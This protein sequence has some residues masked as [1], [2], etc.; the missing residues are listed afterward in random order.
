MKTTAIKILIFLSFFSFLFS[1]SSDDEAK[2]FPFEQPSV[3]DA[4]D[5]NVYTAI[6]KSYNDDYVVVTQK[7][8]GTFISCI[9]CSF[10]EQLAEDNPGFEPEMAATLVE[11]NQN[12]LYLDESFAISS[13][14]VVLVSEAQLN[15][16]FNSDSSKDWKQFRNIFQNVFGYKQFSAVAFN[17]DKT[18]AL[19]DVAN[20]CGPLC[21]EGRL[22]YLEKENGLWI[23]KKT[24]GTWIS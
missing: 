23:I 4:E 6:I 19:V 1:C 8:I 22:Y 5:Y 15:Y 3:I 12:P 20:V 16:I 2:Q 7:T 10:L 17:T 21:S 11:V 13:A 18:K 14:Q 9:D 24:V